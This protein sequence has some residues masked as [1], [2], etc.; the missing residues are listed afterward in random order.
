MHNAAISCHS[1]V[2]VVIAFAVDL[3]GL[4]QKQLNN[5]VT[6][7]IAPEQPTMSTQSYMRKKANKE[8]IDYVYSYIY[9]LFCTFYRLLPPLRIK[10]ISRKL[11][12]C[13]LITYQ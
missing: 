13:Y 11:S 4:Y 3:C 6:I 8:R 10:S 2:G 1:M 7:G 9:D 12:D 5:G